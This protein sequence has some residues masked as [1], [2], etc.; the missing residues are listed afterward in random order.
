MFLNILDIFGRR[1]K[2]SYPLVYHPNFTGLCSCFFFNLSLDA[3]TFNGNS[4]IRYSLADKKAKL[5]SFS[6]SVKTTK[7]SGTILSAKGK[8]DYF[9]IEVSVFICH[10]TMFLNSQENVCLIVTNTV[11]CGKRVND[12]HFRPIYRFIGKNFSTAFLISL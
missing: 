5:N 8:N 1:W 3:M 7:P 6:V 10:F 4:Y 11:T 2:T 9:I 12:I